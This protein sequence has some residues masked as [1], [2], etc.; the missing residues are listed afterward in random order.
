LVLNLGVDVGNIKKR[1]M[2]SVPMTGLLRS[3]WVMARYGQII[4]CNWSATECLSW[5]NQ[6]S[7]VGY[8][9]ADAYNICASQCIEQGYEWMLCVEHDVIIPPNFFITCNERM[10]QGKI[11]IWSGL[12]FTKSVPAEPILYRGRGNGHFVNWKMGDEVWV[13]GLPMGCTMIHSSILKILYDESEVY[14]IGGRKVRK[15][16]ET[17]QRIF[18][19]PETQTGLH[20]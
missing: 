19:D 3:E 12:Y 14:D 17:P 1:V 9:V 7:P 4:P 10:I 8:L 11:P 20:Q 13:D 5:M 2:L 16:F 6:S 15:I 18:I